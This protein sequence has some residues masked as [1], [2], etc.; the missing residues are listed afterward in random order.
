MPL[1]FC[2]LGLLALVL[3]LEGG[4]TIEEQLADVGLGDDVTAVDAFARELLEEIAE[5]AIDGGGG[6]EILDSIEEFGLRAGEGRAAR[7]L[8]WNTRGRL[9]R[10]Y[11]GFQ[12]LSC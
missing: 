6:G 10:K 11:T 9:A 2:C 4:E 3:A 8:N 1:R 7:D 5:V 12:L